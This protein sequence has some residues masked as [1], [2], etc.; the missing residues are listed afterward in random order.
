MYMLCGRFQRTMMF[1]D[2]AE[3]PMM[4]PTVSCAHH[5]SCRSSCKEQAAQAVQRP[6]E[7]ELLGPAVQASSTQA[8]PPPFR[9]FASRAADAA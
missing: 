5:R 2:L 6:R 1:R 4:L 7:P 3:M 8:T 9:P